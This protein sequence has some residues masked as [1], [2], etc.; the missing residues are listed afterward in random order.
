MGNVSI[1]LNTVGLKFEKP[2]SSVEHKISLNNIVKISIK[3]T[4]GS[5]AY[6]STSQGAFDQT[7]LLANNDTAVFTAESGFKFSGELFLHFGGATSGT[8]QIVKQIAQA[9]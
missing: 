6:L 3:N 4:S 9:N 7:Y 2:A 1:K 8:A 5:A